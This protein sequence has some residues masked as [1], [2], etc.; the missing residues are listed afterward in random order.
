[1]LFLLAKGQRAQLG[2][3]ILANHRARQ[4]R[5]LFDVVRCTRRDAAEERFFRDAPT[6]Q[7]RNLTQQIILGVIV[8][9]AFRQLLGHAK[10]HAARNDRHLMHRI[11][12]RHLQSD[13]RVAGFV[14]SR[15][16]FFFVRDDHA[17]ALG[18]HQHFVFGQFEIMH[19]HNFLVVARRVERGF[20]DQVREIR[21]GKSRRAARDDADVDIFTERNL[22]R[23]NLQNAFA[24]AHIRTGD[25]DP[26]IKSPGS[27]QG[28]IQNVG[29]V[30][31]SNQDHA[32]VRFKPVHLNQ[33]LIQSLLAFVVSAAETR[34]AMAT[35][36]VNLVNKDDARRVLL[37]LLE[38]IAHA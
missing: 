26:P 27:Q 30:C 21:A 34:A 33:Q 6:H 28:R 38:K 19:G 15:D 32:V 7:D 17:L 22:T 18:A 29:P 9:V 1:M 14:V 20:V 5:R 10:R 31:R 16:A 2:H 24:A 25:D 23:V 12:V 11:G 4:F 36:G 3:A 37:A 13:Q 35:D 8:A